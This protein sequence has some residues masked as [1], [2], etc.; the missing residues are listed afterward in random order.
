MPSVENAETAT[1][2]V[3]CEVVGVKITLQAVER[4]SF[5]SDLITDLEISF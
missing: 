1:D 3:E 4:Y 2:N 5:S